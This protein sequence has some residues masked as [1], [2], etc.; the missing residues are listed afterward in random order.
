[1]WRAAMLAAVA[2]VAALVVTMPVGASGSQAYGDA[3]GDSATAAD[4]TSV[5]VSNDDAGL[6]TIALKFA[7]RTALTADDFFVIGLDTDRNASTGYQAGL[8]YFI[9][10]DG[11][12]QSFGLQ[13]W[14]GSEFDG[15][16]PQTT[17]KTSDGLT[18][19]INRSELGN[20]QSFDFFVA[21]FTNSNEDVDGGPDGSA[22]WTY[23][24]KLT[25]QVKTVAAAFAPTKPKA[26]KRFAVGGVRVSLAT[27]EV[28]AP[29]TKRCTARLA[30]KTLRP[31]GTCAWFMPKTAK[32]E[33]LAV[34]VTVAYGGS[35]AVKVPFSFKVT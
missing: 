33:T 17:L 10:V 1:M 20:V 32:G 27:G 5:V 24:L 16:V 8:E 11:S 2:A 19:Q 6:I 22:V 28:V 35:A 21:A 9:A 14:T 25:P 23:S 7:N 4:L 34:T 30:G 18:L 3:T 31:V 13:K 26:G 29:S 12:D 15:N